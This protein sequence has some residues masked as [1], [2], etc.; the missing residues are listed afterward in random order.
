[1]ALPPASPRPCLPSRIR[2]SGSKSRTCGCFAPRPGSGRSS[3]AGAPTCASAAG[4]CCASRAKAA[5]WWPSSA[6][7]KTTA[8]LR[9]TERRRAHVRH[10][11][12]WWMVTLAACA[13]GGGRTAAAPAAAPSPYGSAPAP[14]PGAPAA[15]PSRGTI[16][17][18]PGTTRYAVHRRLHGEQHVGGQPQVQDFGTTI[19]LS[20]ALAAPAAPADSSGYPASFRVDSMVPD[21]GT[22]P[23]LVENMN[24][25]RALVFAGRLTPRGDFV[26]AT[27]RTITSAAASPPEEHGGVVAVRIE[28]TQTYTIAGR[29]ANAGQPFELSG[30]GV[31][32]GT[33]YVGLDGRYL[34]GEWRDSLAL[35]VRLPVQGM[36]VPVTQVVRTSV[37]VLP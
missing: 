3:S 1:M 12:V 33:G 37:A 11:A 19:F 27:P 30:A 35:N 29:G 18:E 8:W 28:A 6:G 36:T 5:R 10:G 21:S 20:A 16:R 4:S 7:P 34:G 26:N 15:A 17:Y 25:A 23:P 14:A 31:G 32:S 9:G 22:P 24:R 13:T 2:R